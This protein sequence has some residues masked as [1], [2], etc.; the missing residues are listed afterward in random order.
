MMGYLSGLM[1]CVQAVGISV[2]S[3]IVRWFA[4]S[5]YH[6]R[7]DRANDVLTHMSTSVI[8]VILYNLLLVA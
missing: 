2:G 8:T 6:S 5:P 7:V 1:L 4:H 3:H